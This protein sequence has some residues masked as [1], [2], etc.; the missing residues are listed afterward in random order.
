MTIWTEEYPNLTNREIEI[1]QWIAAGKSDRVIGE[2][3]NMSPKTVNYHVE[4]VKRKYGVATRV[5]ALVAVIRQG[6]LPN[7]D[8][9]ARRAFQPPQPQRP[10][11]APEPAVRE[12]V[13]A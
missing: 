5:Q 10:S 6:R 7:C 3:L 4:K 12:E 13:A 1:L 8:L 11:P 9:H 2:I